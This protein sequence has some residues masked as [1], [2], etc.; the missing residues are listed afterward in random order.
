M[1]MYFDIFTYNMKQYQSLFS[2]GKSLKSRYF[3]HLFQCEE[4]KIVHVGSIWDN[5]SQQQTNYVYLSGSYMQK[6]CSD[7]DAGRLLSDGDELDFAI[8]GSYTYPEIIRLLHILKE[9]HTHTVL[10]PYITPIQRLFLAHKV[11]INYEYRKELIYFLDYP[12]DCLRKTGVENVYFLYQNGK[13]IED[14]LD[15]LQTGYYFEPVDDAVIRVVMEMEGHNIPLVKAGYIVENNWLFY[16]G[17]FGPDIHAIRQFLRDYVECNNDKEEADYLKLEHVL[18]LFE[19]KFGEPPYASIA[20]FHG[21]IHDNP[22]ETSSIMMGKAF[23]TGRK[24][25]AIIPQDGKTC[26]LKCQY[27]YDYEY[28]QHYKNREENISRMGILLLG[29]VNLKKYLPQILVYFWNIERKTRAILVPNCGAE[30]YWN[31]QIMKGLIG[32]D[33]I[34]WVIPVE[35]DDRSEV[36]LDILAFNSYNHIVNINQRFG[37]CFSGYLV[38]NDGL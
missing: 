18:R 12:Y 22:R 28:L 36:I 30:Q 6:I 13:P 34:Y 8:L 9:H 20:L 1:E 17:T 35:K 14:N 21:P 37:Y 2:G 31:A 7:S 5:T 33:S 25:K 38:P 27:N 29:N 23:P 24:C 10:I 32:K 3:R 4:D 11:P 26:A 15:S 16:M 19:K